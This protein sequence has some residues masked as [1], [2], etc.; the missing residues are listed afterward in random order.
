MDFDNFCMSGN[1]NEY[2]RQVRYLLIYCICGVSK[3]GV[4][5]TFMTMMSCDRVCFMC[6][7][8]RTVSKGE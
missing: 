1:G 6:G 8:A 2:P 5:V 7:K 4:T 3:Y